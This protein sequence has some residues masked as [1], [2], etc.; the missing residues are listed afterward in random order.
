VYGGFSYELGPLTRVGVN[1]EQFVD[2]SDAPWTAL[3]AIVFVTYGTD[4]L[5]RL[6]RP[7]PGQR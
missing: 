4:R 2:R 3:R 7:L 1:A 5:F 6:D